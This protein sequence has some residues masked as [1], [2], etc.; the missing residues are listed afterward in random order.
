MS[1][2]IAHDTSME[3]PIFN[4]LFAGQEEFTKSQKI[5]IKKLNNLNLKKVDLRKFP[6]IKI[7][8]NIPDE[9]TLF[10]TI[11]VSANDSLVELFLN[12]KIK[13]QEISKRLIK[14]INLKEFKKYKKICPQNSAQIMDLHKYVS[15]KI[16]NLSI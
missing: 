6:V 3:I 8:S 1:K 11:I 7:L 4:T 15:S 14:I 16:K 13:F 10:E 9:N 12:K 5:N 2:I